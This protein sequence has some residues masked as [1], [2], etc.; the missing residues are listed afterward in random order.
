[1]RLAKHNAIIRT[2][3]F[4]NFLC[5][6]GLNKSKYIDYTEIMLMVEAWENGW[7]R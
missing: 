6:F 2:I 4:G 7:H 3:D 5:K 1:M